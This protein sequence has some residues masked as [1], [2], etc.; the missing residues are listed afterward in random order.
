MQKVFQWARWQHKNPD[1]ALNILTS[2]T[3]LYVIVYRS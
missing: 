2:G 1:K 3:L